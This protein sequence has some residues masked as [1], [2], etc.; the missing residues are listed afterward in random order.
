MTA[1]SII[2]FAVNISMFLVVLAIGLTAT[3]DQ[4]TYL[5]RR[6]GLLVRSLVSMHV[7]MLVVSLLII[8]LLNPAP[9]IKVALVAISLSPVPPILPPKQEKAGG[10]AEYTIGLLTAA[11]VAAIVLV[12]LGLL[13]LGWI[14]NLPLAIS[15][16]AIAGVVLLSIVLP[17]GIGI[18][19]NR[20]WPDFAHRVAR[21]LSMAAMLLLVIALIPILIVAW[22]TIWS[23]VGN[24]LLLALVAFALI[25]LAVGHWLGGPDSGERTVLALAT[26]ARHPGVAIAI[27]SLN[28]P[29]QKGALIVVLFHLIVSTVISAPYVKWRT[30]ETARLHPVAK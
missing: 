6:P 14:F 28:F 16:N 1:S 9:E 4:A 10:P 8:A 15:P 5:L 26:S 29:D 30:Q 11:S 24:G 19:I 3:M 12:P 13:I 17:L 22:P 27:A 7:V 20:R 18:V 21:P 23:F 25:G 2:G